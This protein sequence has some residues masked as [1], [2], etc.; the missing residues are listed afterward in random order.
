MALL[1][2]W[3]DRTGFLNHVAKI[4]SGRGGHLW[5]RLTRGG[6]GKSYSH[7]FSKWFSRLKAN[8]GLTNSKVVF[9]SFRK[10]VATALHGAGVPELVAADILGHEHKS[11]SYRVYSTGAAVRPQYDAI[12]KIEYGL[13]LLHLYQPSEA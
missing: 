5:P 10:N 13:N 7:D 8:I 2:S 9:H 6:A 4:R 1:N 3:P 11:M 12:C